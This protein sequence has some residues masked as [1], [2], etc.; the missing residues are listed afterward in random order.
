MVL[1]KNI[2]LIHTVNS[3]KYAFKTYVDIEF[4]IR[5]LFFSFV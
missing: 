5:L 2:N 1:P 4:D 3:E